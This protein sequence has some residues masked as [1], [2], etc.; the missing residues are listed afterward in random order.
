MQ[1]IKA[2]SRDRLDEKCRMSS[3]RPSKE[4]G[5]GHRAR[6][7]DRAGPPLPS[8]LSRDVTVSTVQSQ[9]ERVRKTVT[10]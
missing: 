1:P 5:R 9:I 8:K 10:L 2:A 7:A 6:A 3:K 4:G